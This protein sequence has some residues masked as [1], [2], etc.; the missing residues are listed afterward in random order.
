MGRRIY[1][2]EDIR[3]AFAIGKTKGYA[4]FEYG[5][6]DVCDEDIEYYFNHCHE[7]KSVNC[8]SII[9]HKIDFRNFT[10]S[11][12]DFRNCVFVG[13]IFDDVIFDDCFLS[14]C[15]FEMCKLANI[16]YEINTNIHF[17]LADDTTQY[18][19]LPKGIYDV[20]EGDLNAVR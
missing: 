2:A 1:D 19:V 5:H 7:W 13:C 17:C 6:I 15:S 20:W 9:F 3:A 10:F 11:Q 18:D 4:K 8:D 14:H 16:K 12:C